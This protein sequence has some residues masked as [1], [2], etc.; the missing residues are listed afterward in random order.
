MKARL[1]AAA[2]VAALPA[3]ALAAPALAHTELVTSTPKQGSVVRHLPKAVVL[4]F[5]EAP[6]RVVSAKVAS[7]GRQLAMK[8]RLNPKNHK[9]VLVATRNDRVGP[10]RV[11]VTL[12]APDGDT[13]LVPIT[14]R[15]RR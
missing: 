3:L 4:S 13:Q 8:A 10:Y 1:A 12:I 5:T 9:Q 2:A 15:V 6:I 11:S 14:F 7:S